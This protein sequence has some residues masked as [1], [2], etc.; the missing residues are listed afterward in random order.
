MKKIR[1]FIDAFPIMLRFRLEGHAKDWKSAWQMS[2][3]YLYLH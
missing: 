3:M 2:L 1:V